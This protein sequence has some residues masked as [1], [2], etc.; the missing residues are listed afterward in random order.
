MTLSPLDRGF[1]AKRQGRALRQAKRQVDH[2]PL[3]V[4]NP[5]ENHFRKIHGS[6]TANSRSFQKLIREIVLRIPEFTLSVIEGGLP[7]GRD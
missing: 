3:Q 2:N 1:F 5:I 6:F 7:N 4:L